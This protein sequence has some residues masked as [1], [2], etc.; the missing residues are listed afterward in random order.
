MLILP[1]TPLFAQNIS[2]IKGNKTYLNDH[3]FFAIY[4]AIIKKFYNI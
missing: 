4:V 2:S 1:S 3:G